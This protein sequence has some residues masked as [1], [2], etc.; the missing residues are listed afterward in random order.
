MS[1]AGSELTEK[2]NKAGK[3]L[4]P[5]Q[6]IVCRLKFPRE[7]RAD[8]EAF[9]RSLAMGLANDGFDHAAYRPESAVKA[10]CDCRAGTITARHRLAQLLS[11]N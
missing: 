10:A 1:E 8:I 3:G 11:F 5:C 9:V 7:Y 2:D 6:V 4:N